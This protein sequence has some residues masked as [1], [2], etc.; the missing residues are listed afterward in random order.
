MGKKTDNGNRCSFCG[1]G[2]KDVNLLIG[3]IEGHICDSCA[4]QAHEIISENL[5]SKNKFIW[6]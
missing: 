1:R 2:E 5:K 4:E 6:I 3:G